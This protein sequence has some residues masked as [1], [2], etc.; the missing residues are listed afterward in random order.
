MV[1]IISMVLHTILKVI[2]HNIMTMHV[3]V[4]AKIIHLVSRTIISKEVA[5]EKTVG[6]VKEI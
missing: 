5:I 2:V 6:T 1:Y 3:H 4:V